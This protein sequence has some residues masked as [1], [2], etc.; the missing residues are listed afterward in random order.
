MPHRTDP[1]FYDLEVE[2]I[3]TGMVKRSQVGAWW[4]GDHSIQGLHSMCDCQLAGYFGAKSFEV[5][6]ADGQKRISWTNSWSAA[7]QDYLRTTACKHGPAKKFR[8][9]CAILPNGENVELISKAAA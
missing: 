2:E 5:R 7:Q 8:P 3:K 1:M 4:S 9:V 6:D